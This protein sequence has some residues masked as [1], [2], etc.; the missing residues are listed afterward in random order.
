MLYH[1]KFF[2]VLFLIINNNN[3]YNTLH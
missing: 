3:R 1:M 2:C